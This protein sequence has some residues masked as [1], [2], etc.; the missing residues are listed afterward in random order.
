MR[1]CSVA[2]KT[3]PLHATA[4]HIKPTLR[5]SSKGAKVK[6]DKVKRGL[7]GFSAYTA[8]CRG[9]VGSKTN[10]AFCANVGLGQ[11]HWTTEG[12]QGRPLHRVQDLVLLLLLQ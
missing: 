6:K 2:K 1:N 7:K 11:L 8:P 9:E 5:K 4:G 3:L 12:W 10:T